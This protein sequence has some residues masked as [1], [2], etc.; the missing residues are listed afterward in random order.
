MIQR[1]RSQYYARHGLSAQALANA[2]ASVL[3]YY[4]SNMIDLDIEGDAV[5]DT[6]AVKLNGQ[7]LALLKAARPTLDIWFTLAVIPSSGLARDPTTRST[8]PSQRRSLPGSHL[9]ST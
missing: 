4:G 1:L 7:A 9:T 5:Y 3:D 8:R 2:Y 6:A